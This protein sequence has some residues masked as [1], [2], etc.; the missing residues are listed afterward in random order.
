MATNDNVGFNKGD[1]SVSIHTTRVTESIKNKLTIVPI[2]QASSQQGSDPKKNKVV[3]LR[4]LTLTWKV[5]G[6]ITATETK[7]A[8]EVKDELRFI[9]KGAQVEGGTPVIMVYEDEV[10]NVY[11]ED[12]IIDKE[13]ND[14]TVTNYS[15]TDAQEYTVE[16]FAIE[17]EVVA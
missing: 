8:K 6:S 7:T 3:D 15:G 14:D 17:G 9:A 1:T 12:L 5:R 2:A 11:L 13:P 16:V 10:F 4:R